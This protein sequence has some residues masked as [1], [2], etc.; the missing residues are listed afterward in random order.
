M[1][2]E[3]TRPLALIIL[4]GWGVASQSNG[5]AIAQAHTPYYDAVCAKYPRTSLAASGNR[6]GLSADAPGNAEV[7]HL[8]IGAGRIVQTETARIAEAISSGDFLQNGVLK[9][10]FE[11]VSS[12]DSAVHFIG[13]VS[14]GGVHSAPETLFALLRMAK[15]EGVREAFIH[16]ILDGRDVQPRT[17]DIYVDALEIKMADIGLGKIASLC[18]RYFAMD[19]SESW[20]RTARAY[21]MLIHG[22][23]ERSFDAVSAIRASFLRGIADEFIAPIIIEKEMDVPLATIKDGDLVIFFNHKPEEMRQLVRSLSVS[24]PSSAKP[25]IDTI[26]LIEYDRS[27]NL[28]VAFERPAERNVLAEIFEQ[29]S[30]QNYRITETARSAHVSGY[31][32]CNTDSGNLYENRI[33]VPTPVLHTLEGDPESKSFKITDRFLRSIESDGKAVFIVNFPAPDL[34][35]E[36]GNFQKTVEAMQY[37]DTCLGGVLEKVQAVNGVVLITSSHG[38]CEE[39]TDASNGLPIS[40]STSN[41]VPFHLIDHAASGTRLSENGSLEDVA[42]TILGILGLEKP[43]EMT[44]CDLR[45][46]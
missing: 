19:S 31:F 46:S 37:V 42:P 5:N 45:I 4:D 33:I 29:N 38:N 23:G 44:G 15:R 25:R 18:G 11:K 6:V 20:E 12:G 17:A 1:N 7:G 10:A 36:T 43:P 2:K 32:N 27:L 35:A 28:P 30:L 21:T 22:E 13:L 39:M 14:D 8:T 3:I 26:C 9:T 34:L 40:T 41:P 16:G 24:D